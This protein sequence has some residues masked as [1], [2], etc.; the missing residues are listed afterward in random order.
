[1]ILPSPRLTNFG[2]FVLMLVG[3]GVALYLQHYAHLEPCPLCIFQRVSLMSMGIVALIAFIHNP[4]ALGR[5][6]YAGLSLVGALAGVGVAGRH[7]W[8]QHLPADEVP[9]CGPGLD[10]WMDTFPFQEVVQKV[11]RGSG[12]CA[13][14]DWMMFGLSL[15]EWTLMMFVGLTSVVVW[16]LVRKA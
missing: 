14:V 6:I 16:Q 8:L 9:S 15:P 12:E 3:M 10:Y 13:K 5:R 1:M 7:V 11:L 4:A 2:L